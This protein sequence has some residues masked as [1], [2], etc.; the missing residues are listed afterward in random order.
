MRILLNQL[1]HDNL[2]RPQLFAPLMPLRPRTF[3]SLLC[4][5]SFKDSR[6]ASAR[7]RLFCPSL[8]VPFL[9][10]DA[11]QQLHGRIPEQINDGKL[12]FEPIEEFAVHLYEE[13]RMPP[14]SKKLSFTPTLS[15]RSTS[16]QIA[17]IS[18]S[19]SLRGATNG[20]A[21]VGREA[22][23]AGSERLSGL[24]LAVTGIW[25]RNTKTAGIM[26]SGSRSFRKSRSSF[27]VETF[28]RRERQPIKR[29]PS[30]TR[31]GDHI[32]LTTDG[33]A[34]NTT[35]FR[36]LIRNPRSSLDHPHVPEIHVP[37]AAKGTR[38]VR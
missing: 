17:A 26:C 32:R 24:P 29:F 4:A 36:P 30:T 28:H 10:R 5:R 22:S 19:N 25:S 7:R 34:F 27:V 21:S 12:F 31:L 20:A 2:S 37:V 6:R 1:H 16:R 9:Y 18:R 33:Q 8:C 35:R 15:S 38:R 23:G 14:R 3:R 11:V 13:Q